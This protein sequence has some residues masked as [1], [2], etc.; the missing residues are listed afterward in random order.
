MN[1]SLSSFE[2]A[3]SAANLADEKKAKDIV[4]LKT[5]SVTSLADYFMIASVESRAQMK[6]LA[7][8]IVKSFQALHIQPLGRELDKG[9]RWTLLDFG[10]VVVHLFHHEERAFYSLERFWSHATEIPADSWLK[11]KRQAS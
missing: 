9:G 6:T 5:E 4:V 8:S 11:E 3:A 1:T 10:S 2:M 7:E